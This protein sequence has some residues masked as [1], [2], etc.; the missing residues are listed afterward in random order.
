MAS[1][2]YAMPQE[3]GERESSSNKYDYNDAHF[4]A[5]NMFLSTKPIICI[6]KTLGIALDIFCKL[7]LYQQLHYM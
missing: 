7:F 4:T 2:C 3:L 1:C 5:K 6:A